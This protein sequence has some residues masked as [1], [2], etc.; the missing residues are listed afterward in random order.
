LAKIG[1]RHKVTSKA[2]I[3]QNTFWAI[4]TKTSGHAVLN[5]QLGFEICVIRKIWATFMRSIL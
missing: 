1:R 2:E 5:I 3:I 4:F